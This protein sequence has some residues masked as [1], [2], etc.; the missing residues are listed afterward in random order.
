MNRPNRIHPLVTALLAFSVLWTLAPAAQAEHVE[1]RQAERLAYLAHE[2]E[3]AARD[4]AYLVHERGY[5]RHGHTAH[6]LNQDFKAL[7]RAAHR[8]YE[9]AHYARS[10]YEARR[11]FRRLAN[12]Y[13]EARL[14]FRGFHGST[15]VRQAFHRINT[16]METLYRFYTGRNLYRDDPYARARHKVTPRDRTPHRGHA[17]VRDRDDRRIGPNDRRGDR[18]ADRRDRGVGRRDNDDRRGR[19]TDTGRRGGRRGGR[20]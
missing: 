10:P 15:R 1:R 11:S 16:P 4:A 13:Y 18:R 6:K 17:D 3:V 8:F 9:Q 12:L 5:G 14:T 7:E 2:L 20:P 19:G